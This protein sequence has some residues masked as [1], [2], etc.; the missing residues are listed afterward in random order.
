MSYPDPIP[1]I[2]PHGSICTLSGASGVGKTALVSGWIARWQRGA[3]I[4]GHATNTPTEIGLLAVD[5]PWRDYA[6]WHER[7]GVAPIKHL[8]LRDDYNF[9]WNVFREWRHVPTLFGQLLDRPELNL[10]P[11]SLLII[12]PL[13]LFIPG[14]LNDYKDTAIGMGLLDKVLR[15]R[16]L[17]LLGI[18]HVAKQ[19]ANVQD[20]YLRAQD[21]ILGSGGQIGYT[22]TAMYLLSPEESDE[23]CHVAGWIP[24]QAKEETFR[25]KRDDSGLFV[26]FHIFDDIGRQEHAYACLPI[27]GSTIATNVLHSLI[28]NVLACDQRTAYR[29]VR[30][31]T[32][33]GRIQ[34]VG[35][36]LYKR[37]LA[38]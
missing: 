26:P 22:E 14:R 2:L 1:V 9:D 34:K 35:R 11:G 6:S 24:H 37:S 32:S 21:R 12:D 19:K 29:Y 20:R 17:T 15:A 7:A 28:C 10:A 30:K 5:R 38:N 8:A 36:G 13:P 3:S 31:L 27:D 4:N 18:F 25:Y 16:Q 23:P 33:D